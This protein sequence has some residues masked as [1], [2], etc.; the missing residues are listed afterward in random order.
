M[1]THSPERKRGGEKNWTNSFFLTTSWLTSNLGPIKNP[2]GHPAII[3]SDY[4]FVVALSLVS[5]WSPIP[6]DN[7]IIWQIFG[8]NQKSRRTPRRETLINTEKKWNKL[9]VV[10]WCFSTSIKVQTFCARAT[11]FNNNNQIFWPSQIIWTSLC[12]P[13]PIT[14][15]KITNFQN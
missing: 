12:S 13:D 15:A 4:L 6:F 11:K 5:L 8:A 7:F 2:G 3:H 1:V 10:I 14:N 9:M